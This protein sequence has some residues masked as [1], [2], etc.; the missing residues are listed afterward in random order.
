MFIGK[1]K[2]MFTVEP[3]HQVVPTGKK[4]TV[5]PREPKVETPAKPGSR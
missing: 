1:P 5:E 4:K 2:R 3:L